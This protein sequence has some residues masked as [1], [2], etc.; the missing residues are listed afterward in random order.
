[1]SFSVEIQET[2]YNLEVETSISNIVNRLEIESS[3]FQ[4]LEIQ[5][6]FAGNVIF[7]SDIIG[8]DNYIANFIDEYEIDCG[9]P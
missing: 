8:L 3:F 7:A 9:T 5:A 4:T 2:V 6:G 1:M